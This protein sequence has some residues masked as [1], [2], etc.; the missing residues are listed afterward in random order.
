MLSDQIAS[1]FTLARERLDTGRLGSRTGE[2]DEGL[3]LYH[4]AA[5]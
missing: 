2:G 1:F 3:T 5:C 4:C